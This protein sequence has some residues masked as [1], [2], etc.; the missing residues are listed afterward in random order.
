MDN[1]D[2]ATC[3]AKIN[4]SDSCIT[5]FGTC[6]KIFHNKC[7]ELNNKDAQVIENCKGAR[8]F[9]DVCLAQLEFIINI[10]NELEQIKAHVTT[11]L[12]SFRNILNNNRSNLEEEQ[13]GQ[14]KTYANVTRNKTSSEVVI[15]KPKTKQESKKTKEAIQRNLRPAALEVG[16]TELK[17]I[18]EGGVVIKCKNKEEQEKIKKAAEKKLTKHYQIKAPELKNPCI[19]ITDIEDKLTADELINCIKKQNIF[20]QETENNN[21]VI[22]AIKKMR[23]NYMAIIECDPISFKKILAE[24]CLCINWSRCRVFE[25]VSI[26]RCFKCA[27]F[28]H[29]ADKCSSDPKCLNCGE[30][31]HATDKCEKE[32]SK[33]VNCIESNTRLN[34]SLDTSHN[35][36]DKNCPVYLKK[37]QIQKQKIKQT[38]LE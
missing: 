26:F 29:H 38:P 16:I 2:C 20:L 15:I 31:N 4:N 34:L 30:S 28:D 25:Y 27:G 14:S 18:K 13:F 8:W 21:L 35:V 17:S 9:C 10:H 22:R 6:K 1:H 5:C 37:V 11:E 36:Y 3:K 23:T 19:K 32:Y 24:G 12:N 7:I 33:C